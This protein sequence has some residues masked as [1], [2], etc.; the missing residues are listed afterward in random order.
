MVLYKYTL[1]LGAEVQT[2]RIPGVRPKVRHV[3]VQN[4]KI[5][6]W[7]EVEPGDPSLESNFK[8]VTTGQPWNAKAWFHVGTVLWA[9]GLFVWHVLQAVKI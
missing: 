1:E 6:L 7:I 4:G 2:L 9:D 8:V 3:D 5:T